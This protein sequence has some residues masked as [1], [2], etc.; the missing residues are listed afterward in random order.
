MARL[1]GMHDMDQVTM[2][3]PEARPESSALFKAAFQKRYFALAIAIVC[4]IVVVTVAWGDVVDILP[5][6]ATIPGRFARGIA[7]AAAMVAGFAIRPAMALRTTGDLLAAARESLSGSAEERAVL[8]EWFRAVSGETQSWALVLRDIDYWKD[9]LK[10]HGAGFNDKDLADVLRARREFVEPLLKRLET[11]AEGVDSYALFGDLLDEHLRNV[12]TKTENAAMDILQKLQMANGH[13]NE[14]VS[15]IRQS[16]DLSKDMLATSQEKLNKNKRLIDGLHDYLT[17]RTAAVAGDRVGFEGFLKT[18]KDLEK[19]LDSVSIVAGQTRMLALN[20]TIEASRAGEAG[21][22]FAVVA[23]EIKNLSLQS[24]L[25][26]KTIRQAMGQLQANISGYLA[27]DVNR[28]ATQEDALLSNLSVDLGEFASNYEASID[29]LT[30]LLHGTDEHGRVVSRDIMVAIADVQFQDI[31]GQQIGTVLKGL[32]GLR[33]F[34][35]SVKGAATRDGDE[36]LAGEM[37]AMVE[38][39]R[40]HYVVGTQHASHALVTK[41]EVEEQSGSNIEFF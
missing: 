19:T 12:I 4:V 37:V 38:R 16:D 17:Q 40:D 26:V 34:M 13:V 33:Q 31:V 41:Q 9:V 24:D 36:S 21:R 22:G 14:F 15:F 30:K 7:F 28:Q 3:S 35:G 5:D 29:Q 10:R 18:T 27:K 23:L 11:I 1:D 8:D 6:R 25:A 2:R 39:M 32:D 20:A